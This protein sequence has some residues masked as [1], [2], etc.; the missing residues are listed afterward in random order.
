MYVVKIKERLAPREARVQFFCE[1]SRKKWYV[2]SI[3]G[4][5]NTPF[6]AGPTNFSF[7]IPRTTQIMIWATWYNNVHPIRVTHQSN[8]LGGSN[9][10]R[11]PLN[12]RGR[13]WKHLDDS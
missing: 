5:I 9:K 6:S 11:H 12:G 2:Y 1:T 7:T 4:V 3:A 10:H 13:P 8:H